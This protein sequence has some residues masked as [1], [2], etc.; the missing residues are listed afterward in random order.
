MFSRFHGQGGKQDLNISRI[1]RLKGYQTGKYISW[2]RTIILSQKPLV[3][4]LRVWPARDTQ[5]RE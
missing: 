1:K 5:T 2:G 3:S 4:T